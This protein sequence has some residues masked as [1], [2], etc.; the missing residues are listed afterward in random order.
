MATGAPAHRR[1]RGRTRDIAERRQTIV[2]LLIA[3]FVARIVVT[4][5]EIAEERLTWWAA[6]ITL[7]IGIEAWR[8]WTVARTRRRHPDAPPPPPLPDSPSDRLLRPLERRGPVVLYA[9]A[10]VYLAAFLALAAAGE[11][12]ETLLDVALIARELTT[13]LFLIVIVAAT[14]SVRAGERSPAR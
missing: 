11:S 2:A 5:T 6:L 7:A 9:L 4:A 12:H 10:A 13:V 1:H 3:L 8:A 14:R